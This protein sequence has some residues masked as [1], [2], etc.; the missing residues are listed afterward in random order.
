[1]VL[2]K[3]MT[4]QLLSIWSDNTCQFYVLV[5]KSD[6]MNMKSKAAEWAYSARKMDRKCYFPWVIR[7]FTDNRRLKI[8]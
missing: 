8:C 7:A 4:A 5:Y 1:M 3:G 6:Y 2:L